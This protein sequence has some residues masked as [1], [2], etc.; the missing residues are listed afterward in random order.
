[1]GI[2]H[3]VNHFQ[4]VVDVVMRGIVHQYVKNK[5]GNKDINLYVKTGQKKE[6]HHQLIKRK[7]L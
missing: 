4:L 3:I 5:H 7:I 2:P 6:V 1:M